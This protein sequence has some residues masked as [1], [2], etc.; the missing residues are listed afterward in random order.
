MA[1]Q[2]CHAPATA[3]EVEEAVAAAVAERRGL[4][5]RGGGSKRLLRMPV[6]SAALLDMRAVAGITDYDPDELVLTARAGTPLVEIEAALG[7]RQQMLA[8]EPFDHGPLFGA[9]PGHTTLGGIIAGNVSGSRRLSIG[10]ARDHILGFT[11]VSGRG[12]ALKGGGAVVKNVTGFDLPKLVAGSWGTLVVLITITMR[13]LPRP[14]TETTVLFRGLSDQAANRLMSV[15]LALPAAVSAAAH[16]PYSAARE[17]SRATT[18]LR[19]EG[20]GPSVDARCRELLRALAP[21][22]AG[23]PVTAEE[24][25]AFWRSVRTLDALP[26]EAHV[27]WR[28]SVPP[29]LG[30]RVGE[31][32]ASNE[33][34]Y[35]YD[36]AGGLVWAAVPVTALRGSGA[37]DN[38]TQVGG[39]QADGARIRAIA[40]S[41]GGHAVLVRAP[42]ALR[43]SL[44]A[45]TP[46]LADVD[47]GLRVL[48]QR[49]KAAF[50]PHGI[51]NPGIDLAGEL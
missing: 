14:R 10:A 44:L 26:R 13:V 20:F 40:R 1:Q 28:I 45:G 18:A 7:E 15:A 35:V 17:A 48:H 42:P 9:A 51:L 33:V 16:V 49:L 8:F 11:A 23:E 29:A 41:L 39:A 25:G 22:G 3:A 21:M 38:G 36:W 31:L 34:H 2:Q 19:L 50:D 37:R 24:S 30:W 12:E 43:E 32:L 47:Q 27:L 5:I 6:E 46:A 4:E